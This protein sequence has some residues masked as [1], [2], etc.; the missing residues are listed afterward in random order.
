MRSILINELEV[1]PNRL[2][3]VLNY[4]GFPITADQIIR[5]V[6]SHVPQPQ[7]AV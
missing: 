4:D 1:D 6:N 2:I 7:H 5:L 3:P